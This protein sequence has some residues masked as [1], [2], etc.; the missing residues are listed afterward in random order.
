MQLLELLAEYL[1]HYGEGGVISPR[2]LT[3]S[4]LAGDLYGTL[5][6]A[7]LDELERRIGQTRMEL[8]KADC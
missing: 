5:P 1:H 8:L 2:E 4:E 7:K 3:V 6:S